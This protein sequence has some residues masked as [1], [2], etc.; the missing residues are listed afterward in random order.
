M[1]RRNS[2]SIERKTPVGD[3]CVDPRE[4]FPYEIVGRLRLLF[5]E[6]GSKPG[7]FLD[8]STPSPRQTRTLRLKCRTLFEGKFLSPFRNTREGARCNL[9][10]NW[11]QSKLLNRLHTSRVARTTTSS[12]TPLQQLPRRSSSPPPSSPTPFSSTRR[13]ETLRASP[14]ST[15]STA[16]RCYGNTL[17]LH[18]HAF[19]PRLNLSTLL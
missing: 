1:V 15:K 14:P 9:V 10:G 2:R 6:G 11:H 16:N 3:S 17:S 12:G 18:P 8:F 7:N 5:D 19:H 4:R 13:F